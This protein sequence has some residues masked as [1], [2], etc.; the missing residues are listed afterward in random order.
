MYT[1]MQKTKSS[2]S[3]VD[4][5]GIRKRSVLVQIPDIKKDD[6]LH[7]K[8]KNLV[9]LAVPCTVCLLMGIMQENVDFYFIGHLQDPAI[10][11]G[12]GIANMLINVSGQSMAMGMNGALDTLASSAYGSGNMVLCGVYLNRSRLVIHIFSVP[13]LVMLSNTEF[14]M[15]CL[16]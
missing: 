4:I 7:G 9:K 12:L 2:E 5:V 3:V 13:L 6:Q 14:I 16:G 15:V 11:A 10:V 1:P 8:I